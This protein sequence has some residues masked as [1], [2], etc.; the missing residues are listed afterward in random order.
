MS[1]KRNKIIINT[2]IDNSSNSKPTGVQKDSRLQK[3]AAWITII[4]AIVTVYIIFQDEIHG[5][6]ESDY[7]PHVEQVDN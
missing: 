7:D 4:T 5:L 6:F 2:T 1:D 3:W